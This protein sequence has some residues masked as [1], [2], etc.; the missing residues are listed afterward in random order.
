MGIRP[1]AVLLCRQ[2]DNCDT[3][4]SPNCYYCKWMVEREEGGFSGALGA[5]LGSKEMFGRMKR[6]DACA[7]LYFG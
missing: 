3:A 5:G 4:R 1:I 6:G 7:R 2:D